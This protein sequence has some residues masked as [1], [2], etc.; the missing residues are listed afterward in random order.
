VFSSRTECDALSAKEKIRK[1]LL[2]RPD[3]FRAPRFDRDAV[4]LVDYNQ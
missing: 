2:A 4:L 1:G 3:L